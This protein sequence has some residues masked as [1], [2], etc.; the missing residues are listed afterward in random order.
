MG[1][2]QSKASELSCAE[3]CKWKAW[4]DGPLF[5]P[6][7]E[8]TSGKQ[9][10]PTKQQG[11]CKNKHPRNTENVN[12]FFLCVFQGV[13]DNKVVPKKMWKLPVDF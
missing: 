6:R 12:V 3:W 2:P 11:L 13:A 1:S 8:T 7:E 4:E 10:D 9:Q 5:P